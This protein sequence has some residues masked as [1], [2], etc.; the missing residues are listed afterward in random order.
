M[1][2]MYEA[3]REL[4]GIDELAALDSPVH[5][6]HPVIK[7]L[8]TVIY[9][10]TVVSVPK[11]EL[12]RLVPLIVF[13]LVSYSVSTVPVRT[14]FHKLR[15]ILPLVCLIGIWNPL[16]DRIP[17]LMIG[18]F[19]VTTGMLSFA[20][21]MLKGIF[22]LMAS[23]LLIATCGIEKICYALRSLHV[24]EM[25]VTLLM[26]TFRYISLL[27]QEAGTMFNAYM[28]RAPDQKGVH[29][30]AWGSFLGQLLLRSMDRA[31]VL[32]Q[33]MELRGFDGSF[34]YAACVPPQ[35]KDWLWFS[36][37]CAVI[38]ALR[39]FPAAELLG[40]ALTGF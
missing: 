17:V 24:P 33:S 40:A 16:M 19:T 3:A 14:C 38:L 35:L 10:F 6:M 8:L 20:T 21:L 39:L 27:L 26:I 7:L 4:A 34:H 23:F 5:R 15:F 32:Y 30:S 22:A 25:M 9:I 29:Y 18:R 1:N 11:Y 37:W 2:R 31:Q 13:P 28:L 12:S 36:A